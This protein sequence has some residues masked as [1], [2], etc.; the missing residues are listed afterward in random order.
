MSPAASGELD[1]DA[2]AA[3]VAR[4]PDKGAVVDVV[5]GRDDEWST[6]VSA[7]SRTV[8]ASVV[9]DARVADDWPRRLDAADFVAAGWVGRAR[10]SALPPDA[11]DTTTRSAASAIPTDGPR[12]VG[13][14]LE[15]ILRYR[16]PATAD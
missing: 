2:V 6:G 5:I 16:Y 10:S 7:A 4:A 1:A 13:R 8:R 15:S 11:A 9:D 3:G 12:E 14:P